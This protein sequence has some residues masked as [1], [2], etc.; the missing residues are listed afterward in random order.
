MNE[1]F[2]EELKELVRTKDHN[3]REDKMIDFLWIWEPKIG[4]VTKER[5]ED[6]K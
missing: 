3:L 5:L 2:I 4:V 6:E 1:K